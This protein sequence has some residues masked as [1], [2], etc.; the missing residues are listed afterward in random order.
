MLNKN[1]QGLFDTKIRVVRDILTGVI[2]PHNQGSSWRPVQIKK[3]RGRLQYTQYWVCSWS[4][5][6]IY[7]KH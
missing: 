2:V 6:S 3:N 4:V 7:M 5:T 1:E